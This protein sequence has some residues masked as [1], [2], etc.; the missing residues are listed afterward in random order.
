M[1]NT[2]E[3]IAKTLKD[4]VNITKAKEAAEEQKSDVKVQLIYAFNGTG[5]TRLSKEFQNL[6]SPKDYESEEERVRKILYY[7][8]FT[9]DL[10]HW[11]NDLE[12]DAEPKLH[13]KPNSFTNWILTEQGKEDSIKSNFQNYTNS[14]TIPKFNENNSSVT[15][16]ILE[17]SYVVDDNGSRLSDENG[18]LLLASNIKNIKISK[19]EE[20][21]FIWSIFYSLFEQVI[22]DRNDKDEYSTTP[23]DD[24]EYIFIDDPVSSLDENHLIELAIDI[25]HLIKLSKSGLKFIITT[26]NPLF[27][28][29][30]WN[31]F[32]KSKFK[33]YIL[34]KQED[35]EC[36]LIQQN[37]DSPFSYHLYLKSELEKV[38]ETGEIKKYHFNFLRNIIE[39][40]STFLGKEDWAT[41][42]PKVNNDNQMP[43][44]YKRRLDLYSHSKHAGE[45]IIEIEEADK[46]MLKY[47]VE[48]LNEIYNIEILSKDYIKEVETNE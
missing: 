44:P 37:N 4:A 47:L 24:L 40:T 1:N 41:L 10:F 33:K 35:G 39:K 23:F 46:R 12:N 19:G 34:T 36:E 15:F 20:S 27:Y 28:N 26:H 7:N 8:A 25:A 32:R 43:N 3:D 6:I 14:K 2:L 5:K 21:I 11:D 48:K 9:E 31:E 45:E 42:L 18:D 38:I 16:S 30:L 13:I 22:E 17:D 29:V